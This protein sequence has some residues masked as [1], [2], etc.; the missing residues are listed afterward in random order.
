[1]ARLKLLMVGVDGASHRIVSKM[2]GE[3]R[4][5]HLQK[6]ADLGGF[7]VLNSTFPPH[8]ASGWTSMFTGVNPGEHG[9][10]QFWET[11]SLHYK[12]RIVG[13]NDFH[14][15]PIWK[16]LERH[17]MKVGVINVPMTHP[18]VKLKEGFMISWPLKP[19]LYYSEPRS[20]ISELAKHNLHH[21][22]DL[23][24]MFRRQDGYLDLALEYT[25]GRVDSIRY[26]VE[27]YPVD[28][29]FVVFSEIDRVSHYYWGNTEDPASEVEQIYSETD[30]AIGQ[31]KELVDDNG[32]MM[33]ASDHGF[34]HCHKNFNIHY[35]LQQQ[36]LLNFKLIAENDHTV[37]ENSSSDY[38]EEASWHYS[39][40]SYRLGIDWPKTVVYMPTPG[41]FGLNLN[42]KGREDLGIVNSDEIKNIENQLKTLFKE[43]KNP[44]GIPYFSLRPKEEVY[45]GN[46][47]NLAP[48]YLLIPYDWS[49]M[50]FPS[51][52]Q[53]LWSEPSQTAI[54]RMDGIVF[55]QGHSVPAKH[56]LKANI[57]DITP[58]ILAELNLPIQEGVMGKSLF[59]SNIQ[60]EPKHF[61]HRED[62]PPLLSQEEQHK[63]EER[64]MELGYL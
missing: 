42:K 35:F 25:R 55:A 13:S 36:G 26:L 28:A 10:F 37:K 62:A 23:I 6:M 4:L 20:L 39:A 43:F 64:L 61:H 49:I 44:E 1:M 46:N 60:Y 53:R 59:T 17:G 52:E 27:K 19:T 14:W 54:H 5:P 11:Q 47:V 51:F 7:G 24:T 21:A 30:K 29:L 8:T 15:E 50:P 41:C 34:G 18:P 32:L 56:V 57:E 38:S 9:I 63:I 58:T 3:G 22:S 45:Q 16:T 12:P 48:D 33:V 2:M 40:Q 31:L